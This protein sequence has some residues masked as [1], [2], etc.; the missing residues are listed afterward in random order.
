MNSG[1]EFNPQKKSSGL[2]GISKKSEL[3]KMRSYETQINKNIVRLSIVF[4]RLAQ[5][6][7]RT[8]G[9]RQGGLT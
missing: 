9:A 6:M 3:K 5:S 1:T 2:D 8:V 7:T 4:L